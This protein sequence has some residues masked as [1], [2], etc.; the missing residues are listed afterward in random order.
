MVQWN[1]KVLYIILKYN[2]EL[3]CLAFITLLLKSASFRL[4][5][6]PRRN[7]L[8]SLWEN[9]LLFCIALI[10]VITS[11]SCASKR[12]KTKAVP[13][14]ITALLLNVPHGCCEIHW[15]HYHH[16]CL[17]QNWLFIDFVYYSPKVRNES[18]ES[19][20]TQL[21]IYQFLY[22]SARNAIRLVFISGLGNLW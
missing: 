15:H 2:V 11:A 3:P 14:Y 4:H 20:P 18:L 16:H 12:R 9:N 7:V 19:N 17:K 6:V 10:M 13:V 8:T 1:Y 22:E 21:G 5:W